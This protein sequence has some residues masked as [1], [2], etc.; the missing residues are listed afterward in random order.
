MGE[1]KLGNYM[2]KRLEMLV[3]RVLYDSRDNYCNTNGSEGDGN[4]SQKVSQ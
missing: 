2:S 3:N 4:G 1:K